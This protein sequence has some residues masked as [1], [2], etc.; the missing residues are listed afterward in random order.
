MAAPAES[1]GMS[2][3]LDGFISIRAPL[4]PSTATAAK[5]S[6]GSAGH[7]AQ[8]DQAAGAGSASAKQPAKK[9]STEAPVEATTKVGSWLE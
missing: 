1:D 5:T 8:A 6:S 4:R 3:N 7:K 2:P 9:T